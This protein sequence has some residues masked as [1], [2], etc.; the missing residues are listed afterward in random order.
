V[1]LVH[2]WPEHWFAWRRII[3]ALVEAGRRVIA[4]DLRDF[5][6][7]LAHTSGR[8]GIE[9]MARDLV[10]LL[11]DLHVRRAAIVSHDWGGW[12]GFRAVLDHPHRFTSHAALGIIPPW[13]DARAMVA[14]L[15][16]WGYVFPM[17][18]I[19]PT[20]ARSPRA[21]RFLLDHS[22]AAPIWSQPEHQLARSS[23]LER[24]ATDR[25]ARMTG[26]LYR[27][28]VAR[29]LPLACGPR[30][31]PTTVPTTMVVGEHETIARPELYEPRTFAGELARVE[32][33][34]ARH[35]LA[36]ENPDAVIGHLLAIVG[37]STVAAP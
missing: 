3:P 6:W 7:S 12:I 25:S 27:R 10:A 32:I 8:P 13:L 18:A 15:A 34:R 21:V 23:Y 11:D 14:N 1:L 16:G 36:E 28:L 4:P 24:V 33:P 9:A 5:G 20:I 29:E 35:W 31:P 2:G 17:A 37:P 30:P 22:T 19:G 26:H